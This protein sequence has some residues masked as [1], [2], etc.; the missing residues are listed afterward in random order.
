MTSPRLLHLRFVWTWFSRTLQRASLLRSVQRCVGP[1]SPAHVRSSSLWRA[2]IQHLRSCKGEGT[3]LLCV[4]LGLR[5]WGSFLA[6]SCHY[7]ERARRPQSPVGWLSPTVLTA[8]ASCGSA[9]ASQWSLCPGLPSPGGC[10]GLLPAPRS[11]GHSTAL[12]HCHFSSPLCIQCFE[13]SWV[14]N[15]GSW[16]LSW[17]S[18]SVMHLGSVLS[19]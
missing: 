15:H 13:H 8:L 11:A 19:T 12:A 2:L 14:W 10:S 7:G 9:P 16:V 4:P 3:C 1:D 6:P 17:I 5:A 18:S